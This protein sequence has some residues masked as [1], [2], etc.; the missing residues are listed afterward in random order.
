MPKREETPEAVL[1]EREIGILAAAGRAI[2]RRGFE[3]TRI[4]DIAREAGTSTGTVHYYF[5]TKD[6]VLAA[7]LRWANDESFRQV[8]AQVAELRD[9][10]ARLTALLESSVPAP[11]ELREAF[12][13][14][15]ELS[16][17][18]S[19][20][21]QPDLM[22]ESEQAAERW[23]EL[24]V[25][26]IEDGTATRVFRTGAAGE[27]V[28][29]RLIALGD[30]LAFKSIVGNRRIGPERARELLFRFAEEQLGLA[31]GD[32]ERRASDG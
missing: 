3:A 26:V 31:D 15:M 30:G 9:P 28:A 8:Q 12:I 24:F 5:E 22:P 11:G 25:D 23:L 18:A 32:L 29:D 14:W 4:A 27:E 1:D 10:K 20:L 6:D 2:A 16:L 13:L 21:E 19:R 17:A 7:A